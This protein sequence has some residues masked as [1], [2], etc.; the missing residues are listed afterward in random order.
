MIFVVDDS[1]ILPT[2]RA[3]EHYERDSP[4]YTLWQARIHPYTHQLLGRSYAHILMRSAYIHTH[5]RTHKAASTHICDA[6]IA[7]EYE[8]RKNTLIVIALHKADHLNRNGV[9]AREQKRA[10]KKKEENALD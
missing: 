9:W 1:W 2:E 7:T 10:K 6:F 3:N 8:R 4:A 5:N